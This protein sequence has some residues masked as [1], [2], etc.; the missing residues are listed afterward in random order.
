MKDQHRFTEEEV[1][2]ILARAVDLERAGIASP[3]VAGS[4]SLTELK[5]IASEAG[6]D[7]A[8]V[9]T[10]TADFLARRTSNSSV[11]LGPAPITTATRLLNTKLS[12]QDVDL[13]LRIVEERL[14]RRGL[15]TEALGRVKWVSQQAQLTTEVSFSNQM[16]R[17][18]IDVDG[19][20]P[21]Q[22]RPLLQLIPGAMAVT[23]AV[24]IAGPAGLFGGSLLAVA[25]GAGV[26]GA[27]IG[28]GIW[29]VVA[30][31]TSAATH[32]LADDITAAALA[33]AD[34]VPE[35]GPDVE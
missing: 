27:A 12:P 8:L 33:L 24:S 22:M 15:V 25:L 16:E 29:E 6:I 2:V 10:A 1:R 11:W 14:N 5:E 31:R 35:P 20:Y 23:A 19:S 30:R 34:R 4:R 28:R 32:A 13:L 3:D 21:R 9:E 17:P 7:E 18:R 26:L